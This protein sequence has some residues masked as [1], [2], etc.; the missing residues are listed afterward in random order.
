MTTNNFKVK[1][2][3]TFEFDFND[4]TLSEI[5][6]VATGK[7]SYHALDKSKSFHSEIIDQNFTDKEYTVRVNNT[8]FKVHIDNALDIAIKAMGFTIGATKNVNSIKAPMPGL[9]LDVQVQV[10]DTV[11]Q[12][13]PLLILEAMKMENLLS[14][15]RDGVIKSITAAVGDAVDK[16]QLLIEF[17]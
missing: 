4:T 9:I 7:N 5:D 11:T 8:D 10:G 15:P 3:D 12:D 1:V 16:G 17:E 13:T 2:D 14:S 6:V